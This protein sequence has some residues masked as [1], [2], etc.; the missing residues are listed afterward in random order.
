MCA[1]QAVK[2]GICKASVSS[3]WQVARARSPLVLTSS[4]ALATT[5]L[6]PSNRRV[7]V[8]VVAEYKTARALMQSMGSSTGVWASLLQVLL[9]CSLMSC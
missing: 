1:A 3:W 9:S 7:R 2:A 4:M 6:D 5:L 8:Q